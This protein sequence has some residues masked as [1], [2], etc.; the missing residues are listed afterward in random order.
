M[1]IP[2]TLL[3]QPKSIRYSSDKD[4]FLL[5]CHC[6][7][8]LQEGLPTEYLYPAKL[9]QKQ[10]EEI[11][12]YT[13]SIKKGQTASTVFPNILLKTEQQQPTESY[14]L[15]ITKE[16]IIVTGGDYAGLLYGIQT[17]RQMIT[18]QGAFLPQLHIT[19]APAKGIRGFYHD[20]TR[21]RIPTLAS[22]KALADK[23]SLYKINQLQLY[24]EHSFLFQE[25]SEVWRDNTPLT[26]EDILELDTYC[27]KL[28]IDL[29]P[30]MASFG[31]MYHLLS[32]KSY[33]HLCELPDSEQQPFSFYGRMSHHTLDASNP[34]SLA[35]VFRMIDEY[36]PLFSS[37]YFNLCG[38]ET[39][40]LGKGRSRAKAEEI[41]EKQLYL[42]F[43]RSICEYLVQKGKVPMFWGDVAAAFPEA[44]KE[45]PKETICLN[46]GYA[47][48]Q[49]DDTTK[50]FAKAG[51][52]QILCPGVSGW[53]QFVNADKEAYEN[54]TRMCRYAHQYHALG[55]LN[56]DWGDYGHISCPE[57]SV[58]GMI[59][60][61]AFSWSEQ[62][63]PYEEINEKIS[64]LEYGDTSGRMMSIVEQLQRQTR[65]SWF[66]IVVYKE[67]MQG[68]LTGVD[69]SEAVKA[70][71]GQEVGEAEQNLQSLQQQLYEAI[72]T[73]KPESR[74]VLRRYVQAA[75]GIS[76]FNR[77]ALAINKKE[78]NE[79]LAGQLEYWYQSYKELWRETSKESELHR[80]GDIIFW[81]A[82]QLRSGEPV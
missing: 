57:F 43:V 56:T 80:I 10:V 22:L 77:T 37:N 21:G 63:L 68:N 16:Q 6:E 2:I 9:L 31:H 39:F 12:G 13:I 24:V 1:T 58:P 35:L 15:V 32:T 27:Q 45:L 3:P 8:V 44:V 70:I 55:V 4:C 51:V 20:V 47:P 65:F 33:S 34:D 82:D 74:T 7:I 67:T 26:A 5:S 36:L 52:S 59:Y 73:V 14:T 72:L 11:L 69:V 76:L 42:D 41:G 62:Q 28:H 66:Q 79:K 61:A 19:D 30:S 64:I 60:G 81:Y 29:V 48:D 49:N 54:I 17:L 46:W 23:L 78:K 71:S 38:D 40:D 25:F 18:T 53:N 75:E 50:A